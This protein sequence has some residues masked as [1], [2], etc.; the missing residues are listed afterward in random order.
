LKIDE[1]GNAVRLEL[2]VYVSILLRKAHPDYG[3][4]IRLF[5]SGDL[6]KTGKL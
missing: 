1:N 5:H 6:D 4:A 2:T 3:S